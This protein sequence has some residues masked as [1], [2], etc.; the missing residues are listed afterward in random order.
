MMITEA[1]RTFRGRPQETFRAKARGLAEELRYAG[2]LRRALAPRC[3]RG[4]GCG[5]ENGDFM[6]IYW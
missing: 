1:F 3:F 5:G 2:G 6:V 4:L